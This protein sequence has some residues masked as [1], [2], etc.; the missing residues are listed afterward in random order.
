MEPRDRASA[1]R[2]RSLIERGLHAPATFR[3]ALLEVAP[4]ERDSWLNVVL[5][6]DEPPDDGPELP[7]GCVPYLP[8]AVDALLRVVDEA[9]VG[10]T[11]VFV[12]VGSGAG[13]ALAFVHLLTGATAVG[14]E[15][16][17]PLVRVACELVSRLR[18]SRVATLE[19]DAAVV[20][21]IAARGSVFFLYCPFSG[22]RL[23]QLLG[24]L[25]TLA[26]TRALCVCSLDL[27]LPEQPWLVMDPPRSG[28]LRVYRSACP[29]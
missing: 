23:R 18:L 8:S 12:D 9:P 24:S 19:A 4:S 25:E 20:N 14:L 3:E 10:P 6:L 27:P 13:R 7:R 1:E 11:D 21:D 16:Q 22:E 2:T 29:A 5:G 28:G 15:I 26:R 17:G